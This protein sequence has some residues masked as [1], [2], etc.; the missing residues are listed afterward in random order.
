FHGDFTIELYRAHVED[1]AKILLIH[2]DDQN[3][4]IQNAVFDTIFQ[5]ATQLKDASEIFI[6]EIRNVKHKHR[7]QNLCDILIERIQ[8]LK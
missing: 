1:I 7:N 5:F 4:Q 2:M 6:N 8:K 3:T